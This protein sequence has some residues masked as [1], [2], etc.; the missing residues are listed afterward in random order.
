MPSKLN[1]DP[2]WFFL[3]YLVAAYCD[4]AGLAAENFGAEN[5]GA[6]ALEAGDN[7][8]FSKVARKAITGV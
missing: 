4:A 6:E 1:T 3:I 5:F 7:E 8:P 2:W